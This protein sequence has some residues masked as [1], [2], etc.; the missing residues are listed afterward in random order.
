MNDVFIQMPIDQSEISP[1]EMRG[2]LVSIQQFAIAC[3]I[4]V[5]YWV[6]YAVLDATTVSNWR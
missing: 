4:C 5:S 2:R 6:D 3:G 1:K